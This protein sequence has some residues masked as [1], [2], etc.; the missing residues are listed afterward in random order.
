MGAWHGC[1][2][3]ESD[4]FE[5]FGDIDGIVAGVGIAFRSFFVDDEFNDF[6][7]IVA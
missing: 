1:Y 5:N 3:G 7:F 2:G 4:N 6:E